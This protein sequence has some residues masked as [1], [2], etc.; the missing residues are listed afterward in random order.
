V[1]GVARWIVREG[2]AS[3]L[4]GKVEM[5][6]ERKYATGGMAKARETGGMSA[7]VEEGSGNG[8]AC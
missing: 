4:R 7:K 8:N 5:R 6:G 2:K 1:V 3:D